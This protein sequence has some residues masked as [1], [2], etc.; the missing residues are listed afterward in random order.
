MRFVSTSVVLAVGLAGCATEPVSLHVRAPDRPIAQ[1][2][3]RIAF[4]HPEAFRGHQ[5]DV[6]PYGGSYVLHLK[7]GEASD[8][9]LREIYTRVF[10]TSREVASPQAF[11]Q[12]AGADAPAALL[13]PSIAGLHYL[14]ASGGIRG[15]FYS[16]IEYRYSLTDAH[17]Y[18]AAWSVRG[19]GEF[20]LD[21]ESR[22]TNKGQATVPRGDEEGLLAE[23][24]RR[25]IEAGVAN[26]ARSFERVPEL[27]RLGRGQRMEGVDVAAERQVTRDIGS[28]ARAA[29]VLYPGAFTVQ[30][31]HAALPAPPKEIA[32]KV[33]AETNMMAVRVTLRNDSTHRFVLD[34]AD[35][36]WRAGSAPPIEALPPRVAAAALTRVPFTIA[37]A[38]GVGLAA[39]PSLLA[40]LISASEIERHQT[41]FA[42]W[43]AAI[44][45]ETLTDGIVG[46]GET[47]TGLAYFPSPEKPVGGTLVVRV[48][49]LDEAL[50]YTVRVPMPAS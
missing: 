7:V 13:Q 33:T 34:P 25:A 41:E 23:A 36:E 48:I 43:N 28:P 2:Q 5:V 30:V 46:A 4:V 47:R 19:F 20:D 26:F 35:I 29:E 14:N 31:Q 9:A 15:P 49:D 45:R 16:E 3:A 6:R 11:S 22:V 27:I 50:R 24:P 17:G 42:T 38:P 21:A 40:A 39:L 44:S 10:V 32:Q 1:T 37:V 12:L 8:K 18:T